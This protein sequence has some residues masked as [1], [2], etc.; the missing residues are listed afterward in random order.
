MLEH[1]AILFQYTNEAHRKQTSQH[2][3][4]WCRMEFSTHK[5]LSRRLTEQQDPISGV[6]ILIRKDIIQKKTE[7]RGKNNHIYACLTHGA[8]IQDR[9]KAQANQAIAQGPLTRE[10]L[11]FGGKF[12]IYYLF[13]IYKYFWEILKHFNLHFFHY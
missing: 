11:K 12:F 4:Q 2:I 13:F 7:E 3:G 9:P 5:W 1:Q 6:N 10:G 8:F